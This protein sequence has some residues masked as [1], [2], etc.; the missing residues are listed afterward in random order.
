[1]I[2]FGHPGEGSLRGTSDA[3]E[4]VAAYGYIDQEN[5]KER[6]S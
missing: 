3:G 5:R 4:G 2:C 6:K 1:M